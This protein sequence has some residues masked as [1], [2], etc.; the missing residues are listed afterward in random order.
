MSKLD[1][2]SRKNGT[3]STDTL[4]RM[5]MLVK[6]VQEL[7]LTRDI[8]KI[9]EI[10]VTTARMMVGSEGSTFV[11]REGNFCHYVDNEEAIAS[12]ERKTLPLERL[13]KWMGDTTSQVFNYRRYL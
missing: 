1:E 3:E 13:R 9:Q 6:V 12:L 2:F 11:L 10:V 4:E 7:S 8:K 5:K